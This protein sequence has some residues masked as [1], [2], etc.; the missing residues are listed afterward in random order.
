MMQPR[1]EH[2]VN[3]EIALETAVQLDAKK[4][5][6][7]T[8]AF[9]FSFAITPLSEFVESALKATSEICWLILLLVSYSSISFCFRFSCFQKGKKELFVSFFQFDL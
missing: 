6:L 3:A 8:E 1:Y 7:P 4:S 5:R 2:T 9:A